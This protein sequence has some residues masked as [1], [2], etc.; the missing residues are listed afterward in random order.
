MSWLLG[1]MQSQAATR[2]DADGQRVLACVSR[3]LR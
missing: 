2:E 1:S 3:W